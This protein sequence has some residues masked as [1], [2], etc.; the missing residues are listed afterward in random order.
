MF[1]R[2]Q[3]AGR[4]NEYVS[5]SC[6]CVT[7]TLSKTT[8]PTT[9][10]L[11]CLPHFARAPFFA[12]PQKMNVPRFVAVR[13]S[14]AP[15]LFKSAGLHHR[16]DTGSIVDQLRDERRAPRRA[17]VSHGAEHVEHRIAVRIRIRVAV[18][19]REQPFAGNDVRNPVAIDVRSGDRVYFRDGHA[20]RILRGQVVDDH[21]LHPGGLARRRTLLLEPRE[22]PAVRFETGDD[23][24]QPVAVEIGHAQLAAARARTRARPAAE[25]HG[26]IRPRDSAKPLAGCSHH[27][28]GVTTSTRPSPLMSPAPRP[29]CAATV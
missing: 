24:I 25:R 27:P 28:Y 18:E 20:A 6:A 10:A 5:A 16:A 14:T 2:Q 4:G 12:D 19:M 21:V 7:R 23:V 15:S 3:F 26:M 22:A 8:T 1:S 17:F 29:C 13:I 9:S 11:T